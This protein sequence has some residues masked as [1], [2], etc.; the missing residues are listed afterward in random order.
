MNRKSTGVSR[1]WTRRRS[2]ELFDMTCSLL[3]TG[4]FRRLVDDHMADN[5]VSAPQV[6]AVIAPRQKVCLILTHCL[7]N[8][9]P[10]NLRS[11]GY[12]ARLAAVKTLKYHNRATR[13][14]LY[15]NVRYKDG[16]VLRTGSSK[17]QSS[18]GDDLPMNGEILLVFL[19]SSH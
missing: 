12:R 14:S 3:C 5:K 11:S 18:G 1:R 17:N 2:V 6:L 7:V 15:G 8:G 13:R 9:T 10:S 4:K 16:A 19:A